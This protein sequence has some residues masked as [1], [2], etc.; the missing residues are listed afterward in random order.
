MIA[1]RKEIYE[2]WAQGFADPKNVDEAAVLDSVWGALQL[3]FNN[4]DSPLMSAYVLSS[5]P[6]APTSPPIYLALPRT[7]TTFIVSFDII[8]V[9]ENSNST[10]YRPMGHQPFRKVRRILQHQHLFLREQQ[11]LHA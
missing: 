9:V 1:G 5:N 11:V 7:L 2:C 3:A 4:L 10:G 8:Q 6:I